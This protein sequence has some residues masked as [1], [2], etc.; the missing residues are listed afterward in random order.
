MKK[1]F[2]IDILKRTSFIL[3]LA[4]SIH[5]NNLFSLEM[6]LSVDA[7]DKVPDTNPFYNKFFTEEV[8][9][10]ITQVKTN[11]YS[12]GEKDN[13]YQ[14]YLPEIV[15]KDLSRIFFRLGVADKD[16]SNIEALNTLLKTGCV[17]IN[18]YELI[19]WA[20][21]SANY[22]YN[23]F[24][25]LLDNGATIPYDMKTTLNNHL[26]DCDKPEYKRRIILGQ[27]LTSDDREKR[28]MQIIN[29][30]KEKIKKMISLLENQN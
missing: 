28:K 5:K 4:F 22:N 1:K 26:S 12:R 3:L 30:K 8:Q 23:L 9:K 11:M 29:E 25:F 19:L 21:D 17:D 13:F 10:I 2:K 15:N 27:S 18:K 20:A 24:K 7:A 16:G 14:N 6:K